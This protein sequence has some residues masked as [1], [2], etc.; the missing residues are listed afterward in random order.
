MDF[1]ERYEAE[2]NRLRR[3]LDHTRNAQ[4]GNGA[5]PPVPSGTSGSSAVGNLPSFLPA[6]PAPPIGPLPPLPGAGDRDRERE[7]ERDRERERERERE[8][9]REQDREREREKER[10]SHR[11]YAKME[12]DKPGKYG[13]SI[14]CRRMLTKLYL[15]LQLRETGCLRLKRL[16]LLCRRVDQRLLPHQKRHQ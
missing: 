16:A 9:T 12:V 3:E 15:S 2:L 8:R 5:P 14:C 4:P 10:D 1:D 13:K 11:G 7:R 6:P